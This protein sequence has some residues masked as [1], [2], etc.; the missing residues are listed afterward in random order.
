MCGLLIDNEKCYAVGMLSWLWDVCVTLGLRTGGREK[1]KMCGP[2]T[3]GRRA[4]HSPQKCLAGL[5]S[6]VGKHMAT[7]ILAGQGIAKAQTSRESAIVRGKP[8]AADR[9]L[10]RT[11]LQ[12]TR[13]G[14]CV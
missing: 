1:H 12:V 6:R 8:R 11:S 7:A 9:N 3:A 5:V 4:C 13:E 10:A 14:S 2:K